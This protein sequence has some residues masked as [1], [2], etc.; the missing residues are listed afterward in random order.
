MRYEC[1]EFVTPVLKKG[2]ALSNT[3]EDSEDCSFCIFRVR[4]LKNTLKRNVTHP[5]VGSS[6]QRRV[7]EF[8]GGDS[9]FETSVT[10]YQ[11]IARIPKNLKTA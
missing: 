11:W 9:T 7:Q 3:A 8:N 10:I 6:S 2:Q 4:H 1:Y 5:S